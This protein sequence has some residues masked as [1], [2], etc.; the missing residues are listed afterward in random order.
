M[1]EPSLDPPDGVH[2]PE[3]SGC[4]TELP[5]SCDWC[6]AGYHGDKEVAG[7]EGGI[8]ELCDDDSLH[9][10]CR[11]CYRDMRDSMDPRV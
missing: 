8:V 3:C 5:E 10:I 6:S 2:C 7:C 4:V 11:D 1:S 9:S